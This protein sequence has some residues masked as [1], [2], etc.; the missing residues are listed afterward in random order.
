M[1]DGLLTCKFTRDKV[2]VIENRTF[3]LVNN[4]YH[5]LIA[6]GDSL[7]REQEIFLW[8]FCNTERV[9][10]WI[11]ILANGVSYHNVAFA[12]SGQKSLL[13]DVGGIRAASDVLIRV[14]G[15]LMLAAW[16]GTASIGM[17]IARYYRQT[18]VRS[19]LC[20][21]DLWFAVSFSLCKIITIRNYSFSKFS[22]KLFCHFLKNA[23][24][25]FFFDFVI[26]LK[27]E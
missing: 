7:K 11:Y 13:S 26:I 5:L 2:T 20:G 23:R 22:R 17:V 16:I 27:L 25:L 21:K 8:I 1:V 10:E 9:N 3:D 19:Q 6:A 15:A 4:P 14:H 18:W 12:S 24:V